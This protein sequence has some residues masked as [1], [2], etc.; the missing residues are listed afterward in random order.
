LLIVALLALASSGLG[1]AIGA[2]ARRFQRVAALTIPL[3]F[4]LFFLSGGISVA[5]FLPDWVQ[6]IAHVI[7]TYYG[8]HALQMTV[9]YNSTEDLAR[10][11]L[12]LACTA[13]AA[14][15]LGVVSLRRRL[16]A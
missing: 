3:A 15:V 6:T 14:L 11:L 13:V 7:P 1:V 9:F 4:Y 8:M 5:A 16:A 12:V 2:V 10:D